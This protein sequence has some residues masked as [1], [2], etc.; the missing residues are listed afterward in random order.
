MESAKLGARA[1]STMRRAAI[2]FCTF[3]NDLD[4]PDSRSPWIAP[5]VRHITLHPKCFMSW[6]PRSAWVMPN[7]FNINDEVGAMAPETQRRTVLRRPIQIALDGDG[8]AL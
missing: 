8:D 5:M 6:V 3:P 7:G 2:E 4:L 1:G